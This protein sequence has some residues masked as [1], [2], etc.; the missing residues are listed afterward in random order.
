MKTVAV[1]GGFD[2]I[3]VGHL[4]MFQKAREHGDRLVV[5]LNND[6]W[7][8]KKKGFVFMCEEQRAEILRA[9]NGVDFVW[10]TRHD[11]NPTDMSV[12][13]DINECPLTIDV[14]ANGGDRKNEEDI[15]EAVMCK[16]I[17][18]ETIF[19]VGGEKVESSSALVDAASTRL[20]A[21]PWGGYKILDGSLERNFV[22]KTLYIE[23]YQSTSLQSHE[24][25][26]EYWMLVEGEVKVNLN[27]YETSLPTFS[28][29][30]IPRRM[31]HR[32]T[33]GPLGATM[34]EVIRG[35]YNEEDIERFEDNYGRA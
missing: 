10:I 1:S 6:N 29:W 25:R 24:H 9:I 2:P 23:P 16:Q 18:I 5:I 3:H 7:L 35:E 22:L 21:K 8:K 31:K 13:K 30:L 27:D 28:F 11:E 4:R 17:G 26:D 15:P 33:A 14:F 12:C 34:V 19:N 32:I 20:H